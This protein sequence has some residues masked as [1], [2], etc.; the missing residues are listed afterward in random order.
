MHDTDGLRLKVNQKKRQMA[1]IQFL[2]T[3]DV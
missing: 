3:L 1:G 2:N